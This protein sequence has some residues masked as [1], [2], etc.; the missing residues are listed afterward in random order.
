MTPREHEMMR[1][2][3]ATVDDVYADHIQLWNHSHGMKNSMVISSSTLTNVIYND[4]RDSNRY[5]NTDLVVVVIFKISFKQDLFRIISFACDNNVKS[6]TI[7]V[8]CFD[9]DARKRCDKIINEFNEVSFRTSDTYVRHNMV[10]IAE[11]FG[12]CDY[13]YVQR[14]FGKWMHNV[15]YNV[16]DA[17]TSD[18][19]KTVTY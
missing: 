10:E 11:F 6:L 8:I 17:D 18:V 7:C 15:K 4:E 2:N 16:I 5:I 19:Y 3:R 1:V 9:S 14:G 13:P 12:L